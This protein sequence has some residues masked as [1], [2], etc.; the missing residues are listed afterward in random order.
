[1]PFECHK[2]GVEE[3]ARIASSCVRCWYWRWFQTSPYK[4]R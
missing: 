4:L 1:L 2:E 3:V